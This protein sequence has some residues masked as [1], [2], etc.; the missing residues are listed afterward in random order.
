MS[1]YE[2]LVFD[3]MWDQAVEELSAQVIHAHTEPWCGFCEHRA[4]KD[5]KD[6]AVKAITRD[7]AWWDEAQRWLGTLE[8]GTRFTADDLT[9]CIGLPWGSPNQVGAVLRTWSMRERITAV[10][11]HEASRKSSHGRML[12]IWEVQP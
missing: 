5:A 10:G 3:A 8:P 12:R 11:I 1:T 9:A 4:G 2:E 6:A 7:L